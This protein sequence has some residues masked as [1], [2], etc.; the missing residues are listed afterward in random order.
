MLTNLTCLGTLVHKMYVIFKT[1]H[2][3]TNGNQKVK[4]I[5][6]TRNNAFK[7]K[8]YNRREKQR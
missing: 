7:R 5:D 4:T 2:T 3:T 1:Q 6:V 8:T